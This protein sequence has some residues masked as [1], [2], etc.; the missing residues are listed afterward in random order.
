MNPVCRWCQQSFPV[1]QQDLAFY[2]KVSPVILG[3]KYTIPAPTLCP[4]CRQKRRLV[5]RN[6]RSLYS[7]T[8]RLCQKDM[9][10]IY[11]PDKE[12]VVYCK[13][14]YWGDDWDPLSYGRDVDFSRPFFEQ[15]GDLLAEVPRLGLYIFGDVINSDYTH[16]IQ[17]LKNCYL[18]F[19][20][21]A[22][23]D[24]YYGESFV[25]VRDC[26]D[27]L[28]L[29]TS[30]RCYECINIVN[31]YNVR[32]SRFS[33]NCADSAY[34]IDCSGC[35]NCL[36]CVNLSQQQYCIFNQQYSREEYER[37]AALI[38]N[39]S[40]ESLQRFR[41]KFE[42]FAAT[43][44]K[45]A[46]RGFMNEQV[47]GDNL[48]NCKNVLDSFDC[49]NQRD[50]RFCTNMLMPAED[51]YDINIWGTNTRL[52]YDS[53]CIGEGAE[54]VLF[55]YYVAFGATNVIYSNFCTRGVADLFGCAGLRHKR[56]CILN[57][58]YAR[59]EYEMLVPKI[60]EHMRKTGEWGELFSPS[61][62]PFG[63]NE[64]VAQE[65]FPLKRE[66]VINASVGDRHTDPLQRG[67]IFN[68]S[69]YEPPFPEVSKIITKEQMQRLPDNIK[70]IPDDILNWA[71]TCEIS[72]K[73]YRI[74]KP[75]LKFYREHNLPIPRRHPDQRHRDRLG[76]RNPRKLWERPC[77]CENVQ[78]DHAPVRCAITF[79][80][81][82]A[83]ERPEKV[84]CEACYVKEVY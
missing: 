14:C 17:K 15:F 69:D 56:Y 78:H 25:S 80:T 27:F 76:L 24:S 66:Q 74:V 51:C 31:C 33:Q 82:Y 70:D 6:E 12:A 22:G 11:S 67:A 71:L 35:K 20:G 47:S 49:Q 75:E 64:T 23:E 42:A 43:R 59:E 61:L 44:I 39:G 45:K 18:V 34:L 84:Y 73:L 10:S 54:N 19:D 68:W 53:L 41:Q 4:D 2:D 29:T 9:I 50:C 30:E 26:M 28:F 1:S 65:Y 79:Q 48:G 81:T 21:E 37:Q 3:K 62:S 72:G 38:L 77:D 63:Y 7:G 5:Q 52:C 46:A 83:P 13:E 8:C 57:K 32:F 60:I 55:S 16:D 36:G 40:H 58:Q